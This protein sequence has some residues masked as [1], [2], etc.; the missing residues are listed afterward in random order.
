MHQRVA[1]WLLQTKPGVP[2]GNPGPVPT[3]A[4]GLEPPT[5]RLTVGC[6][7]IELHPIISSAETTREQ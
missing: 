6:S 2:N 1:Y 3:G 4:G 5:V 7:A